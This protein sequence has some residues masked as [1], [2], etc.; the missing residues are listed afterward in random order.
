MAPIETWLY[1]CYVIYKSDIE[2]KKQNRE[3]TNKIQKDEKAN[4]SKE[5]VENADLDNVMNK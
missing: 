2:F 4:F 3:K 1:K 5:Q